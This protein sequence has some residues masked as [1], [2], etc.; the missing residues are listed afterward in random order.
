M[1]A[2]VPPSEDESSGTEEPVADPQADP[3]I[4]P[5]VEDMKTGRV[6]ERRIQDHRIWRLAPFNFEKYPG[7]RS[8]VPSDKMAWTVS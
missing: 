3:F 6:I 5:P 8:N 4:A 2:P 7:M 1:E